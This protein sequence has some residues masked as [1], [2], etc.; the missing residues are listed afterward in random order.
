MI[1]GDSFRNKVIRLEQKQSVCDRQKAWIV[2]IVLPGAIVDKQEKQ[3]SR[4]IHRGFCFG[5]SCERFSWAPERKQAFWGAY[6]SG[7]S[8][9]WR[10][11]CTAQ[12]PVIKVGDIPQECML[13]LLE[14]PG[15]QKP[16]QVRVHCIRTV[17]TCPELNRHDNTV[18][19]L[20]EGHPSICQSC[21][22]VGSDGDSL[23]LMCKFHRLTHNGR[24]LS[25]MCGVW[26][27]QPVIWES[28]CVSRVLYSNLLVN[29]HRQ[30]VT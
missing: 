12:T 18:S 26:K 16:L 27:C 13:K 20:H 7:S 4:F 30:A 21:Q 1:I 5:E 8:G 11:P 6:L 23:I 2:I 15:T 9:K 17:I 28:A 22:P 25:Q 10:L 29:G 19:S 14:S 3:Q 24:T